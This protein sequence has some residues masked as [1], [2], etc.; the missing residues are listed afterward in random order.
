MA[1]DA[2]GQSFQRLQ[3][4]RLRCNRL[5][6][7]TLRDT[8]NPHFHHFDFVCKTFIWKNVGS[9]LPRFADFELDTTKGEVLAFQAVML[10]AFVVL[11]TIGSIH[12]LQ[13]MMNGTVYRGDQHF[14]CGWREQLFKLPAWQDVKSGLFTYDKTVVCDNSKAALSFLPFW[15]PWLF[16]VITVAV[17]LFVCWSLVEVFRAQRQ[18]KTM[19]DPRIAEGSVLFRFFCDESYDSVSKDPI[20]Y[21]V[22]GFFGDDLTWKL[23]DEHWTRINVKYG[24]PR[25]H[26]SHLNAK[27]YEY[28]GW[29][30]D[31]KIA[32]SAE[33]LKIIT[34]Q[35]R[36]LHAVVCG[37]HAD[38]YRRII[39][40]EGREKLGSPYL[41]CFKT[42][43][44]LVAKEMHAGFP[45]EDRV[46]VFLDRNPFEREAQQMFDRLKN[47]QSFPYCSRLEDCTPKS[48]EN[49]T[50]LQA[51]D[52]IAYEA[53]RWH[54]DRRHR[55]SKTR[56][57][58]DQILSHNGLSERYFGAKTLTALKDGI[59]DAICEPGQLVVIPKE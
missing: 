1:V 30:D 35:G 16:V 55:E 59:E 3:D 47:N 37:I 54:H 13:T 58:M 12:F 27:T 48:M 32:Y 31:R 33:M 56:F 11:P 41:V 28:E 21:V 52:L 40:D 15:L 36:R 7:T 45:A 14:A 9:G 29:G 6:N 24:V 25:Y 2:T 20:T 38:E 23:L 4:Q 5:R 39:S 22:A 17:V 49:L 26:A 53:F 18:D 42:C 19:N 34:D 10:T 43:V 46:C 50:P 51:A 44:V 57:V 8:S